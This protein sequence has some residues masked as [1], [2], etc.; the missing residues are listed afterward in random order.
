MFQMKQINFYG[1]R[2]IYYTI[3][4]CLIAL[5]VI[6]V[7]VFGVKVDIQ[8]TGGLI[9]T[10]SYEGDLDFAAVEQTASEVTGYGVTS[11]SSRVSAAAKSRSP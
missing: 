1:H 9:A 2:K 4:A 5:L 7:A 3:S 6:C 8:F 10:Y 11:D